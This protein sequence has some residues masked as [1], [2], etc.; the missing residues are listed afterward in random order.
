M[1]LANIM[2]LVRWRWLPVGGLVWLATTAFAAGTSTESK[3]GDQAVDEPR[4]AVE[5]NRV[6]PIA[7]GCRLS[8]VL[9]NRTTHA[10]EFMQWDL[11]FFDPDGRIAGRMAAEVAP[12]AAG[13]TSVKQF[14]VPAFACEA[15]GK[16]LI[17]DVLRCEVDA[18]PNTDPNTN[19]NT[20]VDCLRLTLPSSRAQIELFK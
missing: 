5:L 7:D 16:V 14:D 20:K 6:E 1:I 4:I 18:D 19:P 10:F 17:N 8:F 13:K 9:Q 3:A 12:L 15:L 2:P 11:F